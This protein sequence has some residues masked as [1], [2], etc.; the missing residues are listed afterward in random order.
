[1]WFDSFDDSVRV[2]VAGAAAYVWLVLLLRVSG[3]RTLSKLN[4]FDFV[5]SVALGSILASAALSSS[6][7]VIEAGLAFVVLAVAQLTV[8]WLSV[9]AGWLRRLV[10]SEPTVLLQRGVLLDRHLRDQRVT[11]DE[12]R[13]AVRSSGVGALEDVAA[14]V[15]ETDGT[16]SVIPSADLGTA[17]ALGDVQGWNHE[18]TSR[19]DR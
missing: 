4:A 2:V 13:Q 1:M 18:G 5:V 15:L 16:L 9:R 14:V 12:V 11:A 3:K 6:V 19:L 8:A 10:K 7:A 17:T